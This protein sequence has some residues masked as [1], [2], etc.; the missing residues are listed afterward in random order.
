MEK[1]VPNKTKPV[2]KSVRELLLLRPFLLNAL[3]LGVIN[4]SALAR[5]LKKEIGA[6]KEA[7]KA[8]I[9]RER[10]RI[11][12]AEAVREREILSLL[13]RTRATLRDKVAIVI[14]RDRLDIPYIVRASLSE[15]LVYL[16]DQTEIDMEKVRG[17]AIT[18]DMVAL[19]LTSPEDIEDVPG[20]VAFV[21]QLLAGR[22]INIREFISCYTDTIIVLQP[23]DAIRAFTLLRRFA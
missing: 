8:A 19:I 20:F 6:S 2:A 21:T 10:D 22:G 3:R 14:S 18:K 11:A 7:I 16:V 15:K 9:L 5:L 13:K 4:Y 17:A 1:N 23:D 12:T